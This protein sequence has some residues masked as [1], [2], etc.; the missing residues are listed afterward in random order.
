MATVEQRVVDWIAKE[1]GT[2]PD[3]LSL[4]SRLPDDFDMDQI[5]TAELLDKFGDQFQVDL[6][7]L[8]DHWEL[9]FHPIGASVTYPFWIP[10]VI[11]G[12][13]YALFPAAV[14]R[15]PPWAGAILVLAVVWWGWRRFHAMHIAEK[16]PVNVQD[17]VDAAIAGKWTRAPKLPR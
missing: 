6:A 17:L 8:C 1:T 9:Y 12:A 3:R 7:A 15:I 14:A 4:A 11:A 10:V 2:P 13:A 16:I 5:D